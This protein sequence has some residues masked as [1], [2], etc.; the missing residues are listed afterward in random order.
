MQP[1]AEPLTA[2][3]LL[4]E[5]A[6]TTWELFKIMV[7][8]SLVAK[9]LADLGV[10]AWLGQ[11][12]GPVMQ[13]LGL[14]A[15]MGLVWATGMVTNLYG[16]LAAFATLAPAEHLTVAQVTVV[17]VLMLVA[18]SLPVELRIAQKAGARAMAMGLIRIGGALLLGALLA[19]AYRLTGTLQ[20][21]AHSFLP[22]AGPDAS[23]AAW[24]LGMGKSLLLIFAVVLAVLALMR[25]LDRAGLTRVLVRL[26]EPLLKRLGMSAQAAPL[27]VIGMLLGLSYGG[28][29]II[30]ET[31][32]GE[33]GDRDVFYALVLMGLAHA[34]I[35]DTFLM[36][37]IG[38]HVSGLLWARILFGLAGT[39]VLVRVV[40]WIPPA[41]FARWLYRRPGGVRGSTV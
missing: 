39:A 20:A 36:L 35:E 26:L 5:A 12:L 32:R 10:V 25:A 30:R 7:P 18:H 37:T 6:L 38:G 8:V 22:A 28:G 29:L 41:A 11:A 17:C 15:S 13:L 3:S 19:H 21:P 34:V 27:T 40:A 23:W 33:L 16:G 24:A 9:V 1:N 31:Q 14:P 2:R 4:R